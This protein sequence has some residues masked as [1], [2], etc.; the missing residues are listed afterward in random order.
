MKTQ[1]RFGPLHLLLA[2][3]AGAAVA[4]AAVALAGWL[5][6][7]QWGLSV[8]EGVALV[9]TQF[10]GEFD[11]DEAAD[12]AL[13][14]MVAALGDRWS[15]YL[16]AENYES[17]VERRANSFV[18]IGVTVTPE[19]DGARILSVEE[20]GP[21]QTAG[22]VPGEVITAA[23][24]QSLAGD[25]AESAADLIRGEEGTQVTLTVLGTDG[26]RRE[27]TL[28]RA[29]IQQKSVTWEM[30][31][32]QIAL[33]TVKNFYSNCA[34]QGRQAL[35][36]AQQEGA[37]AVIFDM[38]NDPGG[39]ITELTDFLDTILPEG[40]IFRTSGKSGGET[41]VESDAQCVDLPMAVL[42]NE[43]SYSAAEFF[44]AQLQEDGWAVIVGS[45]TS[46]KGYSQLTFPLPHGGALALSTQTYHTGDGVSLIGTGLTLDVRVDLSEEDAA[47]LSA[48]ALPHEE[49]EQLQAAIA[50]LELS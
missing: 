30:L 6:L 49:D 24:G 9:N 27:V 14:G 40:T 16:T 11:G 26:T 13:S 47:L 8:L 18:G 39:Y 20:G 45:P 21:A 2:A 41:T 46:G 1:K 32:G 19:E 48:G 44:A 17:Q 10:V 22:L 33:I 34:Q 31:D 12:G 42:V 5:L 36:E 35:E 38:R 28:T 3:L 4:V 7:G 29:T 50:A 15:Y 23:D 43:D 25:A 37:R